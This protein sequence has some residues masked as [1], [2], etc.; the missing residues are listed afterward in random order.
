MRAVLASTVLVSVVALGALSATSA[1]ADPNLGTVPP[2]RHYI[3][4]ATGAWVEVGPR[5]CDNANLQKAF[6]QFHNNLHVVTPTGQGPAAPGLHNFTGGE[7]KA[8][9]PCPPA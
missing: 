9:S 1:L 3:Q 4:N 2:H 5:V 7:I 8:I 6:N